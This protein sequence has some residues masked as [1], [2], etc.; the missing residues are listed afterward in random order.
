MKDKLQEGKQ[1]INACV[2]QPFLLDPHG[3]LTLFLHVQ[4]F[5]ILLH[6]LLSVLLKLGLVRLELFR[7]GGFNRIVSVN[8]QIS[9][10]LFRNNKD[11][12]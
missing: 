4:L 3:L 7:D 9:W 2:S 12:R 11:R 6:P 1:D 5:R 8:R 10:L